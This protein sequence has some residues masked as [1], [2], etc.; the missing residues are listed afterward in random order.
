MQIKRNEATLNRPQGDRII[1]A[2]YVFIDL[3]AFIEQVKDEKAWEKNDRNGITVFKT[4]NMTIVLS[5]LKEGATIADNTVVGLL[6]VQVLKGKVR[7]T[8]P[9][10]DTKLKKNNLVQNGP[11]REF[12]VTDAIKEKDSTRWLTRIM[13]PVGKIKK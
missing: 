6:T 10:G 2:P 12:Y 7:V 8:T 13:T 4:G 9:D 3:P 1:D 5:I 11:M